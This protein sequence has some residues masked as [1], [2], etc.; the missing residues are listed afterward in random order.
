MILE[1]LLMCVQEVRRRG[2]WKEWR[3]W[4]QWDIGQ[5]THAYAWFIVKRR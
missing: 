3:E 5:D 2:Q 1:T 4:E